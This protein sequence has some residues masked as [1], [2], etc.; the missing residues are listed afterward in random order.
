MERAAKYDVEW[1][2]IDDEH[3]ETRSRKD[4]EEVV[5]VSNNRLAE[6]ARELGF[7]SENLGEGSKRNN[8]VIMHDLR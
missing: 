3:A 1:R 5:V 2:S 7:H 8:E 6:W 4:T